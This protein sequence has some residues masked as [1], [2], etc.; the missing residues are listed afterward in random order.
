MGAYIRNG[1]QLLAALALSRPYDACVYHTCVKYRN[2]L[3]ARSS[4]WIR[5]NEDAA[6]AVVLMWW[7][8]VCVCVCRC[9]WIVF[10]S[11]GPL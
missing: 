10:V 11:V 2:T 7:E 4:D 8:C 1:W 3:H 9:I 5:I 6:A